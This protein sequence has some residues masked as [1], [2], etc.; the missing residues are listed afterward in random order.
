MILKGGTPRKH[1][2][3]L[4]PEYSCKIAHCVERVYKMSQLLEADQTL[5]VLHGLPASLV[6]VNQSRG[7]CA[8]TSWVPHSQLTLHHQQ[9]TA[10]CKLGLPLCRPADSSVQP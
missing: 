2:A 4:K 10:D 5:E 8:K 6:T 7:S 9:A 1:H 3:D